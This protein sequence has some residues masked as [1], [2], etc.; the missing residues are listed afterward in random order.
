LDTW[1]QLRNDLRSFSVDGI[2]RIEIVD[3]PAK[4]VPLK[5]LDDY[6]LDSF[7][8]ERGGETQRAKLRR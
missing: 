3:T 2:R 6:P 1:C 4:E 8:I 7:G 5:T